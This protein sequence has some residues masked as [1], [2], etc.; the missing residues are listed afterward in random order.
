MFGT[1]YYEYMI[2]SVPIDQ[3]VVINAM[4]DT[5]IILTEIMALVT[6]QWSVSANISVLKGVNSIQSS[7][8]ISYPI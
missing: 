2:I 3:R 8:V 4:F 1:S 7:L 5:F 6:F